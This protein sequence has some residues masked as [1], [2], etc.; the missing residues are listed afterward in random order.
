MVT[1]T[2]NIV[3]KYYTPPRIIDNSF[4]KGHRRFLTGGS[5]ESRLV[6]C[7]ASE[8]EVF[9]SRHHQ[10]LLFWVFLT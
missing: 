4:P 6:S 8:L 9:T 2:M 7:S 10:E 5:L 3:L 1:R